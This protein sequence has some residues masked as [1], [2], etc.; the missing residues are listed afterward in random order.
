MIVKKTVPQIVFQKALFFKIMNQLEKTLGL[1]GTTI[2]AT[3]KNSFPKVSGSRLLNN[4]LD[5]LAFKRNF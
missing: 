3:E 4:F 1:E 2:T 5:L